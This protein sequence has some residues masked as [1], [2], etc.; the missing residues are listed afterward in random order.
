MSHCAWEALHSVK[1]W[2]ELRRVVSQMLE[3][4]ALRCCFAST[5]ASA[6]WTKFCKYSVETA[7]ICRGAFRC[8]VA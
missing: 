8:G 7:S 4:R 5:T 1:T 6:H 2:I 3:R